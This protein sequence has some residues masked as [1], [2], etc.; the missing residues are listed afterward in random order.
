MSKPQQQEKDIITQHTK[1]MTVEEAEK[2]IDDTLSNAKESKISSIRENCD[3]SSPTCSSSKTTDNQTGP[4]LLDLKDSSD[5]LNRFRIHYTMVGKEDWW[6]IFDDSLKEMARQLLVQDFVVLDGFVTRKL[7]DAIKAELCSMYE[8]GTMKQGLLAGGRT[9]QNTKYSLV[10]VRGVELR[11]Q[12][13]CLY[14][15]YY[16]FHSR[17]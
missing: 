17:P 4:G 16:N 14:S 6:W 3:N 11:R 9:G 8:E 1:N 7:S 5:A 13:K 10:S 12:F 2:V 15:I